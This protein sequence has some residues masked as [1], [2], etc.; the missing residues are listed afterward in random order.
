[1]NEQ[2]PCHFLRS[3]NG[4][5]SQAEES[6]IFIHILQLFLWVLSLWH[7]LKSWQST[8]IFALMILKNPWQPQESCNQYISSL[9]CSC[10]P[11]LALQMEFT[12]GI[13]SQS[14]LLCFPSRVSYTVRRMLNGSADWGAK[15]YKKKLGASICPSL[16]QWP[17]ATP[18]CLLAK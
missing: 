14:V 9:Q 15:F 17:E 6:L 1:M 11:G 16:S 8:F 7:H 12:P 5:F 3:F 10:L 2:I 13:W 18:C 4:R